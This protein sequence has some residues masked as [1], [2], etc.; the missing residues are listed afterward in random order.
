MV[1]KNSIK[2]IAVLTSGGDGPGMNCAIR[3]VTRT[4]IHHGLNVWGVQKGYSGLLEGDLHPMDAS[5]VGNILQRGGTILQT[6]RCKEFHKK[7][8]R[9]EAANI[10]RRKDIDALVVIGGDGSFNGAHL[11]YTEN[12]IPVVGVPGTIDNDIEGSDYT[13]GFDTAVQTAVEAVDKIRDTASSH[14]RTFIVEV[15]GRNSA[16]IAIHVGI[17]TGS[18]N[19]VLSNKEID[20][21][22]IAADIQRGVSR[23]KTFSIILVAEGNS[24]GRAYDVQKLLQNHHQLES[25]VCVL[26]HIQRGGSPTALDRFLASAMGMKAVEALLQENEMM[27]TMYQEGRVTLSPLSQHLKKKNE[28]KKSYYELAKVLSI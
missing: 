28:Y 4:A 19:I 27:A 25:R 17:G 26:G 12:G 23:G 5:S 24:P 3:A 6:S 8:A 21:H 2:S 15:M 11:L 18:E 10:L 7:E 22:E 13:I 16:A 1:N 14:E 9:K 20:H